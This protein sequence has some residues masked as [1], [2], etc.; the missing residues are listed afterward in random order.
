MY[1]PTNPLVVQSDRTIL[2]EVNHQL[3]TE[4]R[5]FLSSFAE[6]VKSPEYIHSYRITPLSVWNAVAAGMSGKEIIEG[7]KKYAKFDIP[8]N[9]IFEILSYA[10]RYGQIKLIKKNN[11]YLLKIADPT[12]IAEISSH[13]S[14]ACYLAERV[15]STE[16]KIQENSRGRLKQALIKIKYP[17]EDLAGYSYGEP[18]DMCIRQKTLNGKD[19]QLREY[20]KQ[21]IAAFYLNGTSRGGN[22]VVVLP[23]GAG[24]TVVGMGVMAQTKTYTLIITTGIVA[25]RQWI[26]ELLDKTNLTINEIGEYTG[27]K[28]EIKPVTITTYQILTW[29][30]QKDKKFKHMQLFDEH[31]WGLI[32]YDEVHLLPAPVFRATTELQSRRRLGLTA[33]LVREDGCED[34]VY[35]LIGPKRYDAPWSDLERQGYIATARCY[36]IRISMDDELKLKYAVADKRKKSRIAAENYAKIPIIK[37]LITKH[38]SERIL[39]IGQY[40]SQLKQISKELEAV[41]ITGK[42][43]NWQ[44]EEYYQKFR[45]GEITVL[46]VSKVANFAI[47]LP[48]ASVAIQV[49]G[50]YGSRQ[51]EAQRLGRLLRPNEDEIQA[52]FYT[53]VSRDSTEQDFAMNRQLFL[54]E[55]GY[56]YYILEPKDLAVVLNND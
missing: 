53:L 35:S 34:D 15:S 20:Q 51:E 37:R 30:S 40:I 9:I 29:R 1:K 6:L 31:D 21:S 38:S 8:Q 23:C 50:S 45:S 28:K 42:T 39:V 24:K 4:A 26:N 11:D 52:S 7:L 44:R 47:D 33:T 55:Q 49:S 41:L 22:G 14:V 32:I 10:K 16:I 36:E 25:V 12:V 3:F 46:V 5:D 43:P 27:E 48:E 54:T 17:V 18:L 56:K 13:Q 19:M 2:L